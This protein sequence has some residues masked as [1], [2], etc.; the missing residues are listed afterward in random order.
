MKKIF[1]IC[2]CAALLT[3]MLAGCCCREGEIRAAAPSWQDELACTLPLLGHRNWILVVDKAFP[4]QSSA[5]MHYIDTGESLEG[6]AAHV[7]GAIENSAHL[8]P[9]VYTDRE[10]QFLDDSFAPGIDGF[11]TELHTL[12]GK[13]DVQTLPHE[14]IFG[15]LDLASGLFSVVVLKTEA[16]LPY[17]SLF[18]ELDCGYW[19]AKQ[20]ARL[21]D[22]CR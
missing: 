3:A 15:K 9:I 10:L 8:K 5:G 21:R 7:L 14:D 13:Y 22:A 6:V 2:L 17:T 18:I 1:S 16:V 4:L 19:S 11:K 12:L 20:E